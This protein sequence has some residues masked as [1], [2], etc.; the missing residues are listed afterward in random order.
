[1]LCVNVVKMFLFS[2]TF[3]M[4]SLCDLNGNAYLLLVY[5]LHCLFL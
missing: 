1:M 5:I 3:Y 4:Y 2:N